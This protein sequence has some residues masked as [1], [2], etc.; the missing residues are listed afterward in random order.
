MRWVVMNVQMRLAVH[1]TNLGEWKKVDEA[2]GGR[3][4]SKEAEEDRGRSKEVNG[5]GRKWK[6]VE[7]GG[8]RR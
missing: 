8:R 3:R 7:E 2:E 6:V 4:R 1:L 5:G